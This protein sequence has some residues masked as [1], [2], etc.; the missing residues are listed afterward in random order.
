MLSYLIWFQQV[1]S[2]QWKNQSSQ[3]QDQ[4]TKNDTILYWSGVK[5]QCGNSSAVD[6][7]ISKNIFINDYI[8]ANNECLPH[9]WFS[10]FS[11]TTYKSHTEDKTQYSGQHLC[12]PMVTT[13]SQHLEKHS[14]LWKIYIIVCGTQCSVPGRGACAGIFRVN[15]EPYC[16]RPVLPPSYV[17]F[18][19]ILWFSCGELIWSWIPSLSHYFRLLIFSC[20]NTELQSQLTSIFLSINS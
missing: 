8:V 19:V 11:F 14:M 2:K 12:D 13:P 18:G 20:W 15:T 7:I 3:N 1:N 16:L 5:S 10:I 9:S 17:T 4:K 6:W